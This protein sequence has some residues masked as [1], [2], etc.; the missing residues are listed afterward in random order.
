MFKLV[1]L[2]VKWALAMRSFR[3]GKNQDFLDKIAI[4]ERDGSLTPYQNAVKATALLILRRFDAAEM[5]FDE[6]S[7]STS[8]AMDGNTVYI[9]QYV[10]ARK[11]GMEGDL[12]KVAYIR[13][14]ALA[15]TC[16]SF[17][18]ERLPI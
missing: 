16:D 11:A 13:V 14:K 9:N 5:A 1:P 6:V 12:D 18:R 8:G 7:R 2:R 10:T 17:L 15:I 3:S 4:I